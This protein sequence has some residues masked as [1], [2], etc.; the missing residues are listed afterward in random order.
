MKILHTGPHK[1]SFSLYKQVSVRNGNHEWLR[2][3]NAFI[4]CDLFWNV[5]K[6]HATNIEGSFNVLVDDREQVK[7]C[8]DYSHHYY[9]GSTCH[10]SDNTSM[11]AIKISMSSENLYPWSFDLGHIH[12]NSWNLTR[13]ILISIIYMSSDYTETCQHDQAISMYTS[14]QHLRELPIEFSTR[15]TPSGDWMLDTI[16]CTF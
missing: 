16:L 4:L 11:G 3:T 5:Q 8:C 9:K 1:S 15:W 6:H 2:T 7:L 10:N 12:L 13:Q 14:G